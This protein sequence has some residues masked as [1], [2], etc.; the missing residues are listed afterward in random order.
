MFICKMYILLK[1]CKINIK[2]YRNFNSIILKNRMDINKVDWYI[3]LGMEYLFYCGY[4]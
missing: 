3:I 2:Y 4:K 1:S